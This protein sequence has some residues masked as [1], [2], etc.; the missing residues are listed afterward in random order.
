VFGNHFL[1]GYGLTETYAVSLGQVEGDLTAGNCGAVTM[2]N[3]ICLLSVPS[4]EYSVDDKPQPR[5]ELLVRGH[6]LFRGYY[7]DPEETAKAITEDGWFKTGDIATVDSLGRFTIIDRVKNVLKLAQ[8]EYI[9]PERIE[10]I[11]LNGCSYLA[12]AYVHGDSLKTSLVAIFGIQPDTFAPYA[13]KLLGRN[14]LPTDVEALKAAAADERVRKADI[15]DLDRVGRKN[16]FAGYE[17]VKRCYL[18]VEPFSIE[19]ELLTPT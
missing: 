13:S 18:M 8:G 15:S 14:I 9:S 1:Q 5:G 17:R 7:K 3:E 2:A 12:Q 11:Y 4:M 16:Q 19:N 10:G 6:T